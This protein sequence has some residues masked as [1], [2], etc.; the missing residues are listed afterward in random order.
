[1]PGTTGPQEHTGDAGYNTNI[2]FHVQYISDFS[3]AKRTLLPVP[4]PAVL[5]RS[6]VRFWFRQD[7]PA[8][9]PAD[10]CSRSGRS[11]RNVDDSR[12]AGCAV[13]AVWRMRICA[14]R[15]RRTVD[16]ARRGGPSRRLGAWSLLFFVPVE[17]AITDMDY[18]SSWSKSYNTIVSNSN[19]DSDCNC[20][21]LLF[22]KKN[23]AME[24]FDG[25]PPKRICGVDSDAM[26]VRNRTG[27]GGHSIIQSSRALGQI[28]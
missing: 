17:T 15:P 24:G 25:T 16:T 21:C 13:P 5:P 10:G 28:R 9:P 20:G 12:L 4:G 3:P 14:C 18:C 23:I 8:L 7:S 19:E 6:G 1:M 27:R 11:P 26:S 22:A 2:H